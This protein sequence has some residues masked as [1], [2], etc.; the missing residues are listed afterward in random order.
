MVS[1]AAT[2]KLI[3]DLEFFNNPEK[4]MFKTSPLRINLLA[5]GL[6]LWTTPPA[7]FITSNTLVSSHLNGV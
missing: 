5:K 2:E 3:F 7:R 6:E 1:P 4:P